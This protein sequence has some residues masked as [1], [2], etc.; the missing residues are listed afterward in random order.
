MRL[1][2]ASWHFYLDQS[3][4]ASIT[5]REILKAFSQRG[6][7]VSTFCGS[8]VDDWNR[9]DAIGALARRG[10]SALRKLEN[11]DAAPFTTFSFR[12]GAINSILFC[13]E[14][15]APIPSRKVGAAFLRLLTSV[16]R[17]VKPDVVLSYGGYWLGGDLLKAARDVGAKTVVLLQNFA[18]HDR[19]YFRGADLVVTPSN[20]A[21]DVY[22]KRL[23]V[24]SVALPPLI[25]W[26]NV[27]PK[28]ASDAGDKNAEGNRL[29]FV[30]PSRNKGVFLFARIATE[31]QRLRPDIPILVVE[32]S[33]GAKE[34][35]DIAKG[36]SDARNIEFMK[37][38]TRPANFF[39]YAKAT[40]VP[41]FFDESFGRVAAESLIAGKPV[42]ASNRGAL[43]ETLGDAAILLDVPKR[44][45][46]E[47]LIAPTSEEARPWVD[48]ITRLWDDP[49]FYE[50]RRQKGLERA[51]LWKYSSVAEKYE[52]VFR[53][54]VGKD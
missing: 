19:N 34:L 20:Y 43:P 38:T 48:A 46:P 52:N 21:S 54:L 3:N 17:R 9:S 25:D 50:E 28:N 47:T 18:Y 5:A 27:V 12:D 14:D 45:D 35:R 8:A 31:L 51:K 40:L 29:L 49:E 16:L 39:R 53:E 33:D 15:R 6:W 41:S 7:A 11:R 10:L 13:P 24:E 1:L 44:Y 4:G 23:G 36:W 2:F 30:N 32:G 22:R 37:N 26:E 42:V